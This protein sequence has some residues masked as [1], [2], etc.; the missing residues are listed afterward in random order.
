MTRTISRAV[1]S[2]QTAQSMQAIDIITSDAAERFA[3]TSSKSYEEHRETMRS[4]PLI[5]RP[6]PIGDYAE[7]VGRSG[8][9]R[10]V[11]IGA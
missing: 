2:E 4:P 3:G 9:D 1:L 8:I 10:R 7:L 11:A 6:Q 5:G